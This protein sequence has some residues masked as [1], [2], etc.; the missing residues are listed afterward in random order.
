MSRV[1]VAMGQCA[2]NYL[3]LVSRLPDSEDRVAEVA[4]FSQQGGGAAATSIATLAYLGA[5]TRFV[6]KI[7]DDHFG[8]FIRLGLE[9]L[10]VDL[11]H[12]IVEPERVSP[13][14]YIAVEMG[15]GRRTTHRSR[16]N[17][18]DITESEI[19]VDAVLSNV[20]MLLIDGTQP[21]QQRRLAAAAR[22]REVPVV[23][24]ADRASNSAME[25]IELADVVIA[26]ERLAMELAPASEL[27][28]SLEK[29][30]RLGPQ[31]SV[32][33]LGPEGAVGLERG[34]EPHHERALDVEVIDTTAAG[35]V[36]CGA[37]A[38]AMSEDWPLSRAMKFSGVAAGLRCR[39]LG[40]RAGMPTLGEIQ[41]TL[42]S[43]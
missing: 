10:G 29:L 17:V 7:A 5:P 38:Y 18:S 3:G 27:E 21:A 35:N 42:E 34:G 37:F 19:D 16:G 41:E 26:S 25:L 2:V 36:Y 8:D 22:E 23:W 9:S 13:F 14:S 1:V 32:I 43:V 20:A 28:R 31:T 6:G 12:L 11:Q 33:T 15:S 30:C 24:D 39:K 4:A 40:P